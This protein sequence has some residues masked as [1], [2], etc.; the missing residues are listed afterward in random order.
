MNV[1]NVYNH[2]HYIITIIY[3]QLLT[4]FTTTISYNPTATTTA[5]HHYILL[6]PSTIHEKCY[7]YPSHK[8]PS[9]NEKHV[10]YMNRGKQIQSVLHRQCIIDWTSL[11]ISNYH[12]KQNRCYT[13]TSLVTVYKIQKY[14]WP[15]HVLNML[16]P[17]SSN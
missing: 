9:I 8:A 11:F 1:R 7:R 5:D 13:S 17:K 15:R 12:I 10:L 2:H 14:N 4:S 16:F 6:L 3:F